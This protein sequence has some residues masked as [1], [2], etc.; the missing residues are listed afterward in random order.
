MSRTSATVLAVLVTA[1]VCLLACTPRQFSGPLA[2]DHDASTQ[3]ITTV[4]AVQQGILPLAV[5]A[6]TSGTPTPYIGQPGEEIAVVGWLSILYGDPVPNPVTGVRGQGTIRYF[7]IPDGGR[8][9]WFELIVDLPNP[10]FSQL[11]ARA[12]LRVRA[13]GA[14]L[15]P[16]P[17]AP[18]RYTVR[19]HLQ[20][21]IAD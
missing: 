7:V 1:S 12:P 5:Q 9:P 10:Q 18:G 16:L 13:T 3:A 6:P 15:D 19:L 11:L 20:F 14:L 8:P 17:P 4:T 21:I 2:L